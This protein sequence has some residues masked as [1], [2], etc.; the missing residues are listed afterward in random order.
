MGSPGVYMYRYNCRYYIV[1][2]QHSSYYSLGAAIVKQLQ[3]ATD[4]GKFIEISTKLIGM[5]PN[6]EKGKVE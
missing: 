1:Y 4:L 6:M 5:V 3:E 2:C